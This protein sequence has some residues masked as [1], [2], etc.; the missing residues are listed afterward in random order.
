MSFATFFLL[1]GLSGGCSGVA[2]QAISG[3]NARQASWIA[4]G[5]VALD[6]DEIK[7]Q[8]DKTEK[9]LDA[10]KGHLNTQTQTIAKQIRAFISHA[11]TALNDDDPAGAG[12]LSSKARVLLLELYRECSPLAAPKGKFVPIERFEPQARPSLSFCF[13]NKS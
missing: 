2:A 11:R 12:V 9:A 6:P 7:K 1:C 4:T 8:I 5:R 3:S 13:P 10:I